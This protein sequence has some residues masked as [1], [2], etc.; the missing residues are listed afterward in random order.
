MRFLVQQTALEQDLE[1][2]RSS[3]RISHGGL[4]REIDE[5]RQNGREDEELRLKKLEEE[6]REKSKCEAALEATSDV[7]ENKRKC[8]LVGMHRK[9]REYGDSR[10]KKVAG[11]KEERERS[12]K[13]EEKEW[14]AKKR[15][16]RYTTKWQ[17]PPGGR[18]K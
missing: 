1:K 9:G 3:E 15:Y 7:L 6:K 14:V 16:K 18:R 17:M 8:D 12:F 5:S 4:R 2:G 11:E 10:L 13:E